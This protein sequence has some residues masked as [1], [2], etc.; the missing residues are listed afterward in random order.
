MCGNAKLEGDSEQRRFISI[1]IPLRNEEA[2]VETLI[3]LDYPSLEML[4]YND[5]SADN[6][7]RALCDKAD[8]LYMLPVR[9]T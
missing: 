2:R 9:R 7:G 8:C 3:E 4:L 5:D 1:L 6:T